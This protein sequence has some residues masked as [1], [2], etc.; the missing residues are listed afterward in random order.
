[1]HFAGEGQPL[2]VLKGAFFAFDLVAYAMV[3]SSSLF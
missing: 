1:L 2:Q 3:I